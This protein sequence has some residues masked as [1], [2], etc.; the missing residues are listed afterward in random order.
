MLQQAA[1]IGEAWRPARGTYCFAADGHACRSLA[2][3]TID[4][5]LTANGIAHESEPLYPGSKRRA[6][7]RL[8]DG[9]LV[10]Y[11]GLLG[12]ADYAVRIAEKRSMA[13]VAGIRLVILIPEDLP[14]LDRALRPWIT[15]L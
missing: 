11:A 15:S 4:D 14:D 1:L 6:D 7:W 2:E 5:F 3:R 10:E 13:E 12:D 9:T 8:S